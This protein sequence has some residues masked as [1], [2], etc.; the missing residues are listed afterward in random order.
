M[1]QLLTLM[2]QLLADN[3]ALK[4]KAHGYHW[5]VESDDFKQFHDF[6]S[7]IY[8]DYDEATDTYA[9]W[10]RIFRAYA[11]YR[12][13]DFFDMSTMPEPVLVGDPQPMLGDLYMSIEKHIEDLKNAIDL[14]T[15]ARENG[16]VDFLSARQTASQKFC[17]MIRASMETE[18]MD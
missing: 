4:F 3:I 9:E 12:L 1:E 2:K 10:L 11:P 7:D 6:F 8:E 14:A 15:T 16:L 5:N 13:T 17:W 18:E